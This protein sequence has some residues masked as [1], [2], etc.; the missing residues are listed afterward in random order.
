MAYIMD[1]NEEE[2]VKVC[3]AASNF[4]FSAICLDGFVR[5]IEGSGFVCAVLLSLE[6]EI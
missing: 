6:P 3:F 2:R 1:T 4:Y 5:H